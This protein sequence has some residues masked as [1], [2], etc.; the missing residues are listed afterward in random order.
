MS[1]NLDV[2][3]ALERAL[4]FAM[5]NS[6]F[7]QMRT[8]QLKFLCLIARN[9]GITQSELQNQLDCSPAAVTRNIDVFGVGNVRGL[10]DRHKLAGFVEVQL[11]PYDNRYK[12]VYL[13]KKGESYLEAIQGFFTSGVI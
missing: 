2:I 7:P 3:Y 10:P 4:D 13:T 1:L 11:D 9:P 12:K 8:N 5:S 6:G